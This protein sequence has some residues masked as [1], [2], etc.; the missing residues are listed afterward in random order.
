[1]PCACVLPLCDV[2][3]G[4]VSLHRE[5]NVL[6]CSWQLQGT[7]TAVNPIVIWLTPTENTSSLSR[8]WFQGTRGP[9]TPTAKGLGGSSELFA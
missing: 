6:F 8:R 4:E 1:M 2:V 9:Y 3:G 5:L 7:T